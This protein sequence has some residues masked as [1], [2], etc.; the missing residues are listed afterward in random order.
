MPNPTH[1]TIPSF[2]YLD[3]RRLTPGGSALRRP[4]AT[5][6]NK[7]ITNNINI[8]INSSNNTI[9]IGGNNPGNNNNNNTNTTNNNNRGGGGGGG[10]VRGGGGRPSNSR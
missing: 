3:P 6:N 10:G 2:I 9:R 7:P 4:I 1:G 5:T 8:N